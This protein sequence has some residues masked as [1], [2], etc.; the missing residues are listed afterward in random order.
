MMNGKYER[1]LEQFKIYYPSI[2]EQAIDWW[3][4]GRVF[5]SVRLRE[6]ELFEFNSIDNTI[7]KIRSEQFAGD[8]DSLKKEIGHNLQKLMTTRS[9]SQG[10]LADEAGVTQAMLSRYIHGTSMPSIDKAYRIVGALG[11]RLTDLLSD[12]HNE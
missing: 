5:I 1:M 2:Y 10:Q 6:G 12:H 7:R 8:E 11:C 9:M 3:P 4:S